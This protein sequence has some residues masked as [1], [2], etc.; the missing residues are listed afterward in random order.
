MENVFNACDDKFFQMT[1]T[2]E[3]FIDC[4]K[5]ESKNFWA[6]SQ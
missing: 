5:T 2:P 4:L 1:L 3:G 6:K